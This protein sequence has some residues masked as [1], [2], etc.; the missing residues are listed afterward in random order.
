MPAAPAVRVTAAVLVV[1]IALVVPGALI[2]NAL[3]ALATDTFVRWELGRDDFPSDR[4]GLTPDQRETLALTGLESIRPGST[5]IVLLERATLP[6]GSPAFDEREL[7]HM[8]DVRTLFGGALRG[9]LV[10]ALVVGV[11]AL[12]LARTRLRTLVPRGLLAGALATLALAV[13]AV[14]VILLGFDGFFTRFH[15]VFFEGD[16]W[17]FNDTDTLIRLYPERLWEDVSRLA[18]VITVAQ[19]VALALL[20]WRWLRAIRRRSA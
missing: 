19:A 7:S 5:G 17:R 9:Q 11:L 18:A 13:L 16:S 1:L 20:A 4:Y 10:A 6:D 15:E 14:P 12:G 2:V 8:R 3:R